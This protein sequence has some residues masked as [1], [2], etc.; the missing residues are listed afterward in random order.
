LPADTAAPHD[1]FQRSEGENEIEGE[2]AEKASRN[3]VIEVGAGDGK[4]D[5]DS[6]RKGW[7]QRLLE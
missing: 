2:P 1:R 5:D 4:S 7:W 3:N 6:P